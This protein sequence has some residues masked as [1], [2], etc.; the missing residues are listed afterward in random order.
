MEHSSISPEPSGTKRR[1]FLAA[2]G[3]LV[4]GA[5]ITLTPI[6]SG[7]LFF[8]NPILNRR[9]T[10]KGGDADG[11]FPVTNLDSLPS[12][13]TPLRFDLRA[14][15]VDAWSLAK[16]QP[17]GS[18]YLRKMPDDQVIAFNDTCPHLGC[19]VEYQPGSKS[20]VEYQPG[21]KSFVCPCHAS[22]FQLDG[23]R[24]N[25]IPPRRLDSLD[26]KIDKASGQIWV[27]YEEFQGG[28][29]QKK[30]V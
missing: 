2:L 9:P 16:S 13:G 25:L 28:Q 14:D 30:A 29:E 26:T 1:A 3:S 5:L 12:D 21:G 19:K 24:K 27:K 18:V 23:D 15:K 7:L 20:F 17:I 8:L 6:V 11:Y 22:A 10:F 4:I